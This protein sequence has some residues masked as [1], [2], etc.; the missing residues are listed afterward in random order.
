M[1]DAL[2]TAHARSANHRAEIEASRH[3]GCFYCCAVFLS[4][5]VVDWCDDGKTALCP[6]C[7]IDAVIGDASKFPV[8]SPEFLKRMREYWF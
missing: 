8:T 2:K 1:D 5:E 6:R 4:A 3:C 7:G